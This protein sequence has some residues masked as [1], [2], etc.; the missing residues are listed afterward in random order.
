MFIRCSEG[1]DGTCGVKEAPG[2]SRA[3]SG[4][5]GR[6]RDAM[7]EWGCPRERGGQKEPVW[8][9]AFIRTSY[10]ALGFSSRRECREQSGVSSVYLRVMV[11]KPS[12]P[13]PPLPARSPACSLGPAEVGAATS[14][15]IPGS[16]SPSHLP[17]GSVIQVSRALLGSS[18]L[19]LW[20]RSYSPG[21]ACPEAHSRALLPRSTRALRSLLPLPRTQVTCVSA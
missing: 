20:S 4:A 18:S 8:M 16:L 13:E 12:P 17:G 2:T 15:P 7:G 6:P 14:R 21:G 3:C 11:P 5:G 9:C 19:K 10:H 1:V